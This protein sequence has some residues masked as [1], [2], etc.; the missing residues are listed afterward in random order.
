MIMPRRMKLI[1]MN[2]CPRQMGYN[3]KFPCSLRVIRP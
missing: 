2:I 1:Q 3:S